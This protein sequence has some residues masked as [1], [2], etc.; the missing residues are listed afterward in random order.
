MVAQVPGTSPAVPAA[1][2]VPGQQVSEAL[3]AAAQRISQR[4][5][6]FSDV[7]H[8]ELSGLG[9][10]LRHALGDGAAPGAGGWQA[11]VVQLDRGLD[12]LQVE[13]GRVAERSP[14]ADERV[15]SAV[16]LRCR[17]L[18]LLAWSRRAGGPGAKPEEAQALGRAEQELQ[19]CEG[20]GRPT[21]ELERALERV[22][23][24]C[25]GA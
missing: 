7:L 6:R 12:E 13:I 23:T 2:P 4:H 24:T 10:R 9:R 22:R 3:D 14:D 20:A 25:G 19:R 5:P 21:G 18:E 16:A 17:A 15:R 1:V 8:A 11:Y